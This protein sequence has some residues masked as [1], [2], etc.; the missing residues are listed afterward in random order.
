M[1]FLVIFSL[2]FSLSSLALADVQSPLT[3]N[4]ERVFKDMYIVIEIP[5]GFE[6]RYE[7]NKQGDRL[8]LNFSDLN[9]KIRFEFFKDHGN[10][11]ALIQRLMDCIKMHSKMK[12]DAG[13]SSRYVY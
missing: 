1:R 2:F 3:Q 8:I 9:W 12:N 4:K 10:K 13:K 5:S 6:E 7:N 11:W